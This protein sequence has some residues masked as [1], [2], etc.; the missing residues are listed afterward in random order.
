MILLLPL[1][2]IDPKSTA[3]AGT[4][5][6]IAMTEG[7]AGPV[8]FVASVALKDSR[9]E[10]LDGAHKTEAE[11]SMLVFSGGDGFEDFLASVPL[12]DITDSSSCVN[13][14]LG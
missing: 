9:S 13:V 10:V 14:W 6:P 8:N 11:T 3:I 7:H 12:D 5:T 1:P 2:A 4:L